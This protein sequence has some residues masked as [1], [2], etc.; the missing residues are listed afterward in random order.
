MKKQLLDDGVFQAINLRDTPDHIR[1]QLIAMAKRLLPTDRDRDAPSEYFHAFARLICELLM[2]KELHEGRQPT[3]MA[4]GRRLRS[5]V[6][7]VEELLSE[8]EHTASVGGLYRR[9]GITL[10]KLH[11]AVPKDFA[12]AF[13]LAQQ[14]LKVVLSKAA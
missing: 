13:T 4:I 9:L 3:A 2:L 12:A 5:G 6:G 10:K 8:A 11:V 14:R 7:D 1:D